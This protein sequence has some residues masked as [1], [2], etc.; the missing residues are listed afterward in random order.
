MLLLGINVGLGNADVA[1]LPVSAIDLEAGWLTYPRPK[2]GI[3]GR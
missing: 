3:V 1:K 2:T